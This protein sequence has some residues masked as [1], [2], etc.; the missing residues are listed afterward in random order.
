VEGI[1]LGIKL[2][3]RLGYEIAGSQLNGVVTSLRKVEWDSFRV[4]FFV[5]A[6]P[7]VLDLYPASYVTSFHLAPGTHCSAASSSA[8]IAW[9]GFPSR[10]ARVPERSASEPVDGGSLFDPCGRA[11]GGRGIPPLGGSA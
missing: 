4:N 8:A 7:G 10:S 5:V 11:L 2:G 6:P 1:T 9:S 3:D